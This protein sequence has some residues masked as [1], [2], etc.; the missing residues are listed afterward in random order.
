MTPSG[1]S[2]WLRNHSEAID[3]SEGLRIVCR[4]VDETGSMANLATLDLLPPYNWKDLSRDLVDRCADGA[5]DAEKVRIHLHLVHGDARTEFTSKVFKTTNHSP[6]RWT[7]PNDAAMTRLM[8]QFTAT[9][10]LLITAA[11]DQ[12]ECSIRSQEVM[13]QMVHQVAELIVD[14]AHTEAAL[15]HVG[16]HRSIGDR[17]ADV[18]ELAVAHQMGIPLE[19]I[20]KARAGQIAL[21]E[22]PEGDESETPPSSSEDLD[23]VRR[24]I[25]GLSAADLREA[26]T[27]DPVISVCVA[28]A[29]KPQA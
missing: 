14:N 29:W 22:K 27:K 11:Q 7:S 4:A 9:N 3:A 26:I 21:P 24:W 8:G 15:A 20:L 28:R 12:Y 1:V 6:D 10:Q 13:V 16:D 2:R 17:V 18:A 19:E 23:V 25:Q 5:P